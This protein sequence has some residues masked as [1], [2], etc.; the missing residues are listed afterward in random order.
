MAPVEVSGPLRGE[1]EP[2]RLFDRRGGNGRKG[3][4][5]MC[6]DGW[7]HHRGT[8]LSSP[9]GFSQDQGLKAFCEAGTPKGD[10]LSTPSNVIRVQQVKKRPVRRCRATGTTDYPRIVDETRS[11]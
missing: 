7:K 11:E 10:H 3:S 8:W 2:F 6:G 1:S 4:R 9:P 5:G